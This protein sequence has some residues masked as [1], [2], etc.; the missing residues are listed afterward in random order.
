MKGTL[1]QLNVSPGGMPKLAIASA[2]VT[3]DGVPGDW[4]RDRRHHGGPDR[5]V[6]LFSE[7]LYDWLRSE[8]GVDLQNGSVGENFTTRGI[9]YATLAVGDRVRVGNECTI[10]ITA[11]RIPCGQLTKW[12][13]NLHQLVNGRSGWVAKVVVEGVVKPGDAIEVVQNGR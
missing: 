10:E 8:H 6:C 13:K 1:T 2:R 7:E 5:A 3:F 4:Q 11:V 12:H 9:D